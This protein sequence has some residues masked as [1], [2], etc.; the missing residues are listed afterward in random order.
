MQSEQEVTDNMLRSHL[1]SS[2][3]MKAA[4]PAFTSEVYTDE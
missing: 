3:I 1:L 4:R 2:K